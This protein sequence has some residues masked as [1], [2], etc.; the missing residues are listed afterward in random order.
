MVNVIGSG[1]RDT[2]TNLGRDQLHFTNSTNTLENGMNPII[3]PPAMD[4]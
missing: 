2:C 1:H 3:L 4:K